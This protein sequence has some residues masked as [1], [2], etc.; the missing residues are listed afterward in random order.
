MRATICLSFILY[1]SWLN[2]A[3]AGFY[4]VAYSQLPPTLTPHRPTPHFECYPF[5]NTTFTICKTSYLPQS[6][7]N[8]VAIDEDDDI[9]VADCQQDPPWHLSRIGQRTPF[10][11]LLPYR[12]ITEGKPFPVYVV[13]TFVDTNHPEFQG[14]AMR[15]YSN[16][17]GFRNPHG[18]HVAA[19]VGGRTYGVNKNA[20]IFSVQV[21]NDDGYGSWSKLVEGL[22]FISIHA[23]ERLSNRAIINISIAGSV[24]TVVE[25]ALRKLK[26]QGLLIVVAAGNDNAYACNYSP[27]RS[28]DVLTVGATTYQDR[29]AEFS[30][31]GKCVDVLAPGEYIQSA[32]PNGQQGYMSGTS[33]ASPIVAGIASLLWTRNVQ[34]TAQQILDFLRKDATKNAVANVKQTPN[35]LAFQPYG[36]CTATPQFSLQE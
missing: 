5:V 3:V 15:L 6:F 17:F 32:L 1:Q 33:M 8:V 20:Q 23:N 28:E 35:L 29:F 9:G 10:E 36:R 2:E 14:R 18:T 26:Q 19:L 12:H 13:D 25:M 21:L 7:D 27:A 16:Q 11:W 4:L 30:N 22:S 31:W 34:L 24:S